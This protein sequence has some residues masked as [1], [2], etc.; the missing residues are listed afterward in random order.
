MGGKMLTEVRLRDGTLALMCMLQPEDRDQLAKAYERLSPESKYHRFLT[1]VPG[2]SEAMLDRLVGGVDGYNHVALVLFLLDDRGVGTPAGVG[3]FVRYPEDPSTA[4]VA[5]TVAEEYRGRG[6][7]SALLSELVAERPPGVRKLKTVVA[8]D[9][10]AAMAM[11]ARL[12][13]AEV[14]DSGACLDVLVE[15][16]P[17]VRAGSLETPTGRAAGPGFIREPSALESPG[18]S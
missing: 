1:G 12:G 15:L 4:D 13:A 18:A 2:L 14:T 10:R 11:L 5:V 17:D 6:V 16:P 8:A 3:R 9:N 7:A